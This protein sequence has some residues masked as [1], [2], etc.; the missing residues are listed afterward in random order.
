[1]RVLCLGALH[2]LHTRICFTE[3]SSSASAISEVSSVVNAETCSGEVVALGVADVLPVI[4]SVVI[5]DKRTIGL[6]YLSG[7][8]QRC[9]YKGTTAIQ[10]RDQK[11][12]LQVAAHQETDTMFY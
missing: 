12:K 6:G 1:M 7:N 8:I 5:D 11:D 2:L 9:Y 3:G 10:V 4:F